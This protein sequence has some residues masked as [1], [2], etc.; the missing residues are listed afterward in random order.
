MQRFFSTFPAGWPGAGLLL[1]RTVVGGAA[2]V[3]GTVDLAIGDGSTL[4]TWAIAPL[5]IV[6]GF[7]LVL[8]FMTPGAGAVVGVATVIAAA[9]STPASSLVVDRF[10]AVLVIVDAIA[11]ALLGPGAHS[12]DAY[13]FGRREIVIPLD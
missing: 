6:G 5:A 3:Q 9:A 10:A 1:L 4:L 12:V 13:L 8:G 7:A 11:I 2:V